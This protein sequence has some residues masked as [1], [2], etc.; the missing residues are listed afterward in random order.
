VERYKVASAIGGVC[1]HI[2]NSRFSDRLS[3]IQDYNNIGVMPFPHL[4]LING[5]GMD[6]KSHYLI[7]RL[8]NGFFTALDKIGLLHTWSVLSGKLLYTEPNALARDEVRG[9]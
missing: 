5:I 9:F 2:D 4:N 1:N 8:Q 7:W 6:Q 3:Y